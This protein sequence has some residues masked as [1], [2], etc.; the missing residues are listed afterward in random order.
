MTHEELVDVL[1]RGSGITDPAMLR[2]AC[3]A[4]LPL[5]QRLGGALRH[6]PGQLSWIAAELG[7]MFT[8]YEH[9]LGGDVVLHDSSS[10]GPDHGVEPTLHPAGDGD[11]SAHDAPAL[12]TPTPLCAAELQW[13][14]DWAGSRANTA[15]AGY[16]Q[17]LR[18]VAADVLRHFKTAHLQ[19]KDVVSLKRHWLVAPAEYAMPHRRWTPAAIMA[20][21]GLFRE[22]APAV[23]VDASWR[24]ATYALCVH[25][26]FSGEIPREPLEPG[27]RVTPEAR[28]AAIVSAARGQD[29]RAPA[30]VMERAG[31]RHLCA[32]EIA[33]VVRHYAA[34]DGSITLELMERAL[35]TVH[36]LPR[37]KWAHERGDPYAV[38]SEDELRT[39][40]GS[41]LTGEALLALLDADF[42]EPV[43]PW[44]N[45]WRHAHQALRM[46][47]TDLRFEPAAPDKP[48]H[49]RTVSDPAR[50]WESLVRVAAGLDGRKW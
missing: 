33:Q 6:D 42:F 30:G 37:F 13:I 16:E 19:G 20:L 50:R 7:A 28:A 18:I 21:T 31:L 15:G 5:V 46:A 8:R 24:A 11:G 14:C 48:I 34:A 41:T 45:P 22:T 36:L 29:W 2:A 3:T 38:L 1:A 49:L 40:T 12:L 23:Q 9:A 47:P 32:S 27:E 35:C 4:S 26:P 43:R 44:Y 25:V 17:G 39:G 10:E